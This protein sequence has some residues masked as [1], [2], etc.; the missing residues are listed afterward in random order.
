MPELKPSAL[1]VGGLVEIRTTFGSRDAA[2]ACAERLVRDR[3][4]A[5]V[6]VDGPIISTYSWRGAIERADEWRCVCKTTLAAR[7]ACVAAIQAGHP[8]EIPQV[9]AAPFEASPAYAAWV[10][11]S[12]RPG[13]ADGL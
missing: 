4:A 13:S 7:E 12:V 9:V 5:C 2:L 3:L 10:A 8:Y 1:L 11:E 6:Q